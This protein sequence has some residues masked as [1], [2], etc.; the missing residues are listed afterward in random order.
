MFYLFLIFHILIYVEAFL[1]FRKRQKRKSLLCIMSNTIMTI[2]N[3]MVLSRT[4]KVNY[5]AIIFLQDEFVNSFFINLL[6]FILNLLFIYFNYYIMKIAYQKGRQNILMC[7][8]ISYYS[9]FMIWLWIM[10]LFAD[11]FS[12]ILLCLITLYVLYLLINHFIKDK[13]NYWLVMILVLF[14]LFFYSFF[15]YDGSAR[16][17]ILLLGY[18]KEAYTTGFEELKYYDEKNVRKYVP[19]QNIPVAS[20]SMGIIQINNYMGLKLPTYYGY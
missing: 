17:E 13:H 2:I 6:W 9:L 20:G 7:N 16:L 8:I 14:G 15:T 11:K 3:L 12:A 5:S 18:P 4:L 1:L 19:V 10:V